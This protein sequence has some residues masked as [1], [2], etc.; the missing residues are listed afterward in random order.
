MSGCLCCR[1]YGNT[2]FLLFRDSKYVYYVNGP[3][4]S[5]LEE[6]LGKCAGIDSDPFPCCVSIRVFSAGGSALV[7]NIS[8]LSIGQN[9]HKEKC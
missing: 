5:K 8:K 4:T 6:M 9:F 2:A 3:A 1:L 7:S